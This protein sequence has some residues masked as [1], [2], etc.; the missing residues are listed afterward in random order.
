MSLDLLHLFVAHGHLYRLELLKNARESFSLSD[1]MV[2]FTTR[3]V[4]MVR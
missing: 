4:S 3:K 1:Q 2:L